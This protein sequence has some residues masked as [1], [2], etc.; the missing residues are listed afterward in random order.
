ME[1]RGWIEVS[2]ATVISLI[3]SL[4]GPFMVFFMLPLQILAVR[5]GKKAFVYAAWGVIFTSLMFK[6]IFLPEVG[7]SVTIIFADSAFVI[8]LIAGLYAVN[9][10][11]KGLKTI[12]KLLLVSAVSG[13]ISIPVLYYLNSDQSFNNLMIGQIDSTLGLLKGSLAEN[14]GEI[15]SILFDSKETEDMFVL[16]KFFFLSYYLVFYFFLQALTWRFGNK[17]GFR[18]IGKITE[19]SLIKEFCVPEKLVWLFFVPLTITLIKLLLK[20]KG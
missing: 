19:L 7:A 9:Y 13:L 4:S 20:P 5:C 2:L 17:I 8:F 15:N 16:L 6:M 1:R 3:V 10:L 11:F 14:S 18:S 12:E